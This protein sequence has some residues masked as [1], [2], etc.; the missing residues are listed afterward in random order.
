MTFLGLFV[1]YLFI[2]LHTLAFMFSDIVD[3]FGP[4]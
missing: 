3:W 1:F 4:S 2:E